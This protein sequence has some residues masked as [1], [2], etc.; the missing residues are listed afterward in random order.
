MAPVGSPPRYRRGERDID[1]IGSRAGQFDRGK[2][3]GVSRIG[4]ASHLGSPPNS[5]ESNDAVI[6][7]RT[8]TQ[9]QISAI[10]IGVGQLPVRV[11]V[12][13]QALRTHQPPP[14]LRVM[15]GGSSRRQSQHRP[16]CA[17]I[18]KARVHGYWSL[19]KRGGYVNDRLITP[20]ARGHDVPSPEGLCATDR[21]GKTRCIRWKA[22]L[23]PELSHQ[24]IIGRRRHRPPP[25]HR[26]AP[27]VRDPQPGGC[28]RPTPQAKLTLWGRSRSQEPGLCA[29]CAS[30]R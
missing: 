7:R 27:L 4:Q 28:G 15:D 12:E 19:R 10:G 25:S 13:M 14:R 20:A 9:D 6:Q 22:T 21:C 23:R 17:R 1:G 3:A 26:R 8:A 2:V 29:H 24:R 11:R 30:G 5:C 18:G 16:D